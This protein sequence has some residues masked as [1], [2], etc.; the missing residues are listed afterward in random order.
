MAPIRL[1]HCAFFVCFLLNGWV[2]T[3]FRFSV[4]VM[5]SKPTGAG[6]SVQLKIKNKVVWGPP[7]YATHPTGTIKTRKKN[8]RDALS[9]VM[10]QLREKSREK[11]LTETTPGDGAKPLAS[12]HEQVSDKSDDSHGLD[13]EVSHSLMGCKQPD[14][15]DS[16]TKRR[17]QMG[18]L[19]TDSTSDSSLRKL[20]DNGGDIASRSYAE[21]EVDHCGVTFLTPDN[22]NVCKNQ[23]IIVHKHVDALQEEFAQVNHDVGQCL[24][25]YK[26]AND[27]LWKIDHGS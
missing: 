21:R 9:A 27:D 18:L 14:V 16:I 1:F 23:F 20:W 4:P 8:T 3:A 11:F 25:Q 19:D 6:K 2:S 10:S 22:E 17:S 13:K 15:V 7:C 12:S 5:S 26:S 24:D